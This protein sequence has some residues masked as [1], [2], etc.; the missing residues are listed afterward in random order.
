M[1]HPCVVNADKWREFCAKLVHVDT[2]R[3][4]ETPQGHVYWTEVSRNARGLIGLDV[5]YND[6]RQGT[7]RELREILMG[8][9][10]WRDS[11]QGLGYWSTVHTHLFN[12]QDVEPPPTQPLSPIKPTFTP[13]EFIL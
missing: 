12:I 11:P 8:F 3:W 9:M 5:I 6:A 13:M 1:I 2:F 4:S 10:S 7:V